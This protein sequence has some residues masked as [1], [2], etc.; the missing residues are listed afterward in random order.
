MA[1][2]AALALCVAL[3]WRRGR[4]GRVLRVRRPRLLFRGPRLFRQLLSQFCQLLET[5]IRPVTACPKSD[6]NINSL[7]RHRLPSGRVR[8]PCPEPRGHYLAPW[9]PGCVDSRLKGPIHRRVAF[10]PHIGRFR[11]EAFRA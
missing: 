1:L 4:S 5:H 10:D 8:E 6:G 11:A 3:T 2:G 7:L 9:T